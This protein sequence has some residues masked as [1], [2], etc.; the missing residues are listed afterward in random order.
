MAD[1]I[2]RGYDQHALDREY[3]L[4]ERV[5]DFQRH[6]DHYDA[7]SHA[8]RE[9]LTFSADLPYGDRPRQAIDLFPAAAPEAPLMVF[10]HGGYW[11]SF[12]KEKFEYLAPAFVE[13]GAAYAAVGYTLA[14]EVTIPEI[15]DE[16]RQAVVWLWR[17]GAEHG[18]DPTR[19]VVAGH[20]AG[21]HLAAMMAATDWTA[22]G[23]PADLVKAVLPISGVFDLEPL[24]LSYQNEVLRLD[25]EQ[26]RTASPI[27]L[28]PR[29]SG[30]V[31]LAVGAE[32][33]DEF[34]RQQSAF[35]DAWSAAGAA[36]REVDMP[37]YHHFDV[38]DA[39]AAPDS[40][41]HRTALDLL[42]L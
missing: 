32:E 25:E 1:P 4:R 11:Q 10:I 20:S 33:T 26:V 24:R 7:D 8:A 38:V 22:H 12:A 18:A 41:L 42:G 9:R 17:H 23:A 30:P 21:G 39:F 3:R 31:V 34:L 29:L 5:P 37:G 2:Y 36:V 27:H 13:A 14:P 6:F 15:V 28:K 16:V 19:M 40:P 35:A